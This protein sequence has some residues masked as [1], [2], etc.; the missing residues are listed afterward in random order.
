M[1]FPSVCGEV[2][3]EPEANLHP[4]LKPLSFPVQPAV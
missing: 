3:D 2:I 1:T 4:A